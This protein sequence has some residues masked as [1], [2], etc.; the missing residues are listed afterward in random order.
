MTR[1]NLKQARELF[2]S[3][4][5]RRISDATWYRTVKVFNDNF[6]MTRENIV[7]LAEIKTYLPKCDLRSVSVVESV[8]KTRIFINQ[9]NPEISGAKLLEFFKITISRFIQIR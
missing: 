6:P 8:R 1:L 7:W 5:G 2:E 4:Y 3:E 9:Q